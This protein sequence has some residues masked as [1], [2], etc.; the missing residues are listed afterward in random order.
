MDKIEVVNKIKEIGVVAV[1]RG[2]NPEEAVAMSEACIKGGVTA[3]ELAF[4]TPRAHE[5][6]R[7]LA[8]KYADNP[9]VV[10]GAGTV[11]DAVTAR[12]AILE[13]AEFIVSPALDI[14]TIKLC[15]RYRVAVMPGTT[16]LKDVVTALECGADVVK[17]FPGE[18]VGMKA[19]KAIHGPLPQAPLMPTGGVNVDNAGEWIKAGCVAVGAGG[20]LTGG[21]K[22]ADKI[23]ETAKKFI[24]AVKAVRA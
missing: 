16:T 14:E 7:E 9:D 12:I 6:I 10:I 5:A 22:T 11:L 15:N 8:K 1:I 19:I 4:T 23:T 2:N 13:G 21:G 18:V 20:A 3:I 17:I 24:A